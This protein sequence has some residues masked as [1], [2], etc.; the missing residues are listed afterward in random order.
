MVPPSWLIIYPASVRSANKHH[1]SDSGSG[2][3]K[4]LFLLGQLLNITRSEFWYQ[5]TS[6]TDSNDDI[7]FTNDVWWTDESVDPAV[8][9]SSVQFYDSSHQVILHQVA[10]NRMFKD[11]VDFLMHRDAIYRMSSCLSRLWPYLLRELHLCS[12]IR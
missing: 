9:S 12:W 6:S 3:D 8:R 1:V 7:T 4:N 11:L 2:H 10:M 5:I